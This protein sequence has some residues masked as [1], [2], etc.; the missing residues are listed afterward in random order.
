MTEEQDLVY[1]DDPAPDAPKPSPKPAPTDAE[2]SESFTP[3][4]VQLF[5]YSALTFNGHR[6]HYDHPFSTGS[7]GYGGLVVH[8]PLLALLLLDL[9]RRERPDAVVRR[10]EFKALSPLM[11]T[12]PFDLCG[13]DLR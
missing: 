7:E 1:R 11:D 3:S 5:R 6:I 13:A 10:F 4:E 2:V 8:G 9:L 12:D